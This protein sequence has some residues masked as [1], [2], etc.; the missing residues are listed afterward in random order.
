M[1][2]VLQGVVEVN[3]VFMEGV[4]EIEG[5]TGMNPGCSR[6]K[7]HMISSIWLTLHADWCVVS[8]LGVHA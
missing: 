8:G 5:G 6:T 3:P 7:Q 2:G 1:E 4:F